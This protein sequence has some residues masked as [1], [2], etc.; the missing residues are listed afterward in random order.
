MINARALGDELNRLLAT[1][2]RTLARHL[3]EAP[4]Y[5]SPSTYRVW[6][7]IKAMAARSLDH[8]RVLSELL[9]TLELPENPIPFSSDVA[10]FHYTSVETLLPELIA[11]KERQVAAYRRA[12]EHSRGDDRVR[13]SLQ[14][15]VDENGSQLETLKQADTALAGGDAA[16]ASR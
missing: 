1:E 15:L 14:T 11:E 13:A 12:I 6:R 4:P 16:A 3:E 5:I 10:R 7:E 2:T 8:A 9:M